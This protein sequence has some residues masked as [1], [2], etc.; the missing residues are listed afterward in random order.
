ME[1]NYILSK[2]Y[3]EDLNRYAGGY[4][5]PNEA[6]TVDQ[7]IIAM[8]VERIVPQLQ[9]PDVLEMG[10]GHGVWS[11][12]VI[13]RFGKSH[14]VDAS[15]EL[16]ESAKGIYKD[17]L[18]T[19]HS[20][21]EEFEAPKTFNSVICTYVMEHVIDPVAVLGRARQWLRPDGLLFIAVPNA[22]SLHRRLGVAM[23]LQKNV[24]QLGDADISIGHRRVYD[25]PM[26]QADLKAAGF[27]I[28]RE[29][30]MMV[31]P[32]PNSVLTHLSDAQ[33]KGLFDL[34]DEVAA[35]QRGIL[36]YFCGPGE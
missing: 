1:N 29:L 33:L 31:K 34:G 9:G 14:V 11:P 22:G 32:L 12:S 2:D 7:K 21:F 35:D 8:L 6:R 18:T 16:I 26:L 24:H 10:Y 25:G 27:V 15:L 20:Y 30:S 5:R 23:G 19:Y 28:V 13:K 36:A 17:K 3:H 4:V